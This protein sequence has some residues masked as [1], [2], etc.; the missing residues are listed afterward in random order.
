MQL[1]TYLYQEKLLAICGFLWDEYAGSKD[2][3]KVQGEI[4]EGLVAR[5]VSRESSN[6]MEKVLEEFPP[7]QLDGAGCIDVKLFLKMPKMPLKFHEL[8]FDAQINFQLIGIIVSLFILMPLCVLFSINNHH[9]LYLFQEH[10]FMPSLT[11]LRPL[12]WPPSII[13][14]SLEL[15]HSFQLE[16]AYKAFLT[17]PGFRLRLDTWRDVLVFY[18]G[19][20]GLSKG[21][22]SKFQNDFQFKKGSRKSRNPYSF[23]DD[24]FDTQDASIR[25]SIRINENGPMEDF[26]LICST[27]SSDCIIRGSGTLKINGWFFASIGSGEENDKSWC[28][29]LDGDDI[30]MEVGT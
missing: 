10:P 6:H 23:V 15:M 16:I 22:I 14:I 13:D 12:S 24:Q 29:L 18:S 19:L 30:E 3:V 2:H 11:G 17:P 21:M 8:D 25:S 9:D 5:I 28:L 27:F 4:L 1:R 20:G 7:T 26:I